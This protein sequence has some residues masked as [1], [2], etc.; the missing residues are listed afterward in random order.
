MN[1]PLT[2][3]TARWMLMEPLSQSTKSHP[4]PKSSPC[5]APVPIARANKASSRWPSTARRMARISSCVKGAISLGAAFGLGTGAA[6]LARMAPTR[7]ACSSAVLNTSLTFLALPPDTPSSCS[8]ANSA[9]TCKGR[10]G[11]RAPSP[12][13]FPSGQLV[14][15]QGS[16]LGLE[17]RLQPVPAA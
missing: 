8:L 16:K 5:L 13:L 12:L 11:G 17:F 3:A 10:R 7:A 15:R 14:P 6:G 4:R 2:K 9:S 1:P